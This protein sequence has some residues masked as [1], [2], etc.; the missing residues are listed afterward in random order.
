MSL[1]TDEIE[2]HINNRNMQHYIDLGY[3][4]PRDSNA[5]QKSIIVKTMDLSPNSSKKVET[6]C[7]NCGV[8]RFMTFQNYMRRNHDGKTYCNNCAHAILTSG[9]N[10]NKWNPNLTDE[11]RVQRRNY[12]EY[13]EFCRKVKIRDNFT[14]QC[15]GSKRNLEVHHLN[16]YNWDIKGRTDVKNGVSLCK[17]CHKNFHYKYGKIN[18][19]KEQFEEW[20]GYTVNYL[21]YNNI[22]PPPKEVICLETKKIYRSAADAG[23]ELNIIPS[24]IM[25]C[26]LRQEGRI[27]YNAATKSV[28]NMHFLYV[29][30]YNSMTSVEWKEYYDWINEKKTFISKDGRHSNCRKIV[31]VTTH[32]LFQAMKDAS[33]KYNISSGGLTDCCKGKIQHCG[34][35]TDGTKLKWMY[36]EEYI[37]E[38]D[39]GN[40]IEY[41]VA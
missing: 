15:C 11:E 3:D 32:E 23:K 20:I 29:N 39:S 4:V 38:Y 21:D 6:I 14:C 22:L 16:G 31:C 2:V 37:K 17:D 30:D 40:L 28:H 33:K 18:T 12:P 1:I 7:D 24:L 10:N 5:N 13:F 26:C 19:T 35:L 9:E 36:Y 27:R 8:H 34:S 41:K 25:K